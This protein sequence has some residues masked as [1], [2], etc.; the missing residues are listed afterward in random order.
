MFKLLRYQSCWLLSLI[1]G[2]SPMAQSLTVGEA[3]KP[4]SINAEPMSFDYV[5]NGKSQLILVYPLNYSSRKIGQFNRRVIAAGFCPKSIVDMNNRAW[6]ALL[7]VAVSEIAKELKDSPD[8]TCSV[9]AD[10]NSIANNHWGLAEGPVSIV[11]NGD[12]IV[13]FL[14]YGVLSQKQE[15]VVIALLAYEDANKLAIKR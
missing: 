11:V 8:P 6:Y 7:S 1:F 12:G 3:L 14:A 4:L 2:F 15:K 5:A 13:V 10:Y 9:T